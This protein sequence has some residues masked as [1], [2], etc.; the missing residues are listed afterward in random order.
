MEVR[1]GNVETKNKIFTVKRGG[2][3]NTSYFHGIATK[4]RR[5]NKTLKINYGDGIW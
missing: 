3:R 4:R 1:R 5:K 2:D